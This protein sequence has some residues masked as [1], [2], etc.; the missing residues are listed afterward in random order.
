[1]H[2]EGTWFNFAQESRFRIGSKL[3]LVSKLAFLERVIVECIREDWIAFI[4]FSGN[5]FNITRI[6]QFDQEIYCLV[7]V[8]DEW[9]FNIE[10]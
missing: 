7:V 9:E 1:M 4:T 5:N 6:A 3:R 8:E 2:V 10:W